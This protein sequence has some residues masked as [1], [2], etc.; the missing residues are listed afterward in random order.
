MG[1]VE[2]I[3]PGVL[4]R[5]SFPSQSIDGH[6]RIEAVD[7]THNPKSESPRA[8]PAPGAFLFPPLEESKEKNVREV[9]QDDHYRTT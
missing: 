4:D 7:L 6:S 3:E 2:S 8:C 5:S 1:A 9:Y